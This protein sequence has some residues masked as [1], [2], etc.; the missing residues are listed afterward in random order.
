MVLEA[1]HDSRV[2]IAKDDFKAFRNVHG[3]WSYNPPPLRIEDLRADFCVVDD[4]VRATVLIR[5]AKAALWS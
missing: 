3:T 1:R 4:P 5:E 2:A